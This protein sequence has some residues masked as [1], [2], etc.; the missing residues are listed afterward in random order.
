MAAR[1]GSNEDAL[2][3]REGLCSYAMA[4]IHI[5]VGLRSPRRRS[6]CTAPEAPRNPRRWH[7]SVAGTDADHRPPRATA[8]V[9]SPLW[10]AMAKATCEGGTRR[11]G[12]PCV[13]AITARVMMPFVLHYPAFCAMG[14]ARYY[15]RLA[16]FPSACAFWY[17]LPRVTHQETRCL[18]YSRL[19]RHPR[20]W[21]ASVRP[22]AVLGCA[23]GAHFS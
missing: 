19:K 5:P 23:S 11:A 20:L 17:P 4:A 12:L 14:A 6:T 8:Y 18:T 13:W 10:M 15:A 7:K 16:F 22:A 3:A 21:C 9:P 2:L 1:A